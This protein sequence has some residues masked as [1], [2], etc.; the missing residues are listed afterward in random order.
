[1]SVSVD[2]SHDSARFNWTPSIGVVFYIAVAEDP[3]GNPHSCYSMGTDCLM[4]GLACGRYYNASIIGTNLNCNSTPSEV[5]TFTTGTPT[6]H[7][8][9][10]PWGY[11]PRRQSLCCPVRSLPSDQHRGRQRLRH[12]PRSDRLAEPLAFGPTHGDL[13]G[14]E[15]GSSLLH[16]QHSQQLQRHLSALREEIQRHRHLQRRNVFVHVRSDPDGLRSVKD[17]SPGPDGGRRSGCERVSLSVPCGPENVTA[18][19]SCGTGA[20]KV[21]WDIS[22]PADNYTARI[23]LGAAQPLHCNS[24]ETQCTAEGLVCGSSYVVNVFSI[25]DT[26]I[27]LPSADAYVHTREEHGRIMLGEGRVSGMRSRRSVPVSPQ[28]RVRRLTLPPHTRAPR[29]L[30]P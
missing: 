2:C 18:N 16:Q 20:L 1:M 13:A 23:S 24:T 7:V 8:S 25:T 22:V 26:C 28:C 12:Q 27:S 3:D 19:V 15:R 11:P 17:Q 10:R 9:D 30:F 4:G 14:G 21:T 29:T 6:I 5:V